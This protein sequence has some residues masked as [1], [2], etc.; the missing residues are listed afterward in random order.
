MPTDIETITA[1]RIVPVVVLNDASNAEG[2]ASAL[3]AGGL[4]VA[5]V[6]FRT[7]AAQQSIKIM[8]GRG[9]LLVGAGTVITP[10]QVDEAVD[11][12]ASFIVSPGYSR[13]V[14]DEARALG[15]P[16]L[17][18]TVTGTEIMAALSDG[19]TTLKFFP[20]G[21]FGGP[22]TI[23]ALA[24]PFPQVSFIPTGGV[25]LDNVN[26]YLSLSCVPAVGGSWMVPARL[27]D[28]RKFDTVQ[29]LTAAAVRAVAGP[30]VRKD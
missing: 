27:V 5:E 10:R 29:E 15:V 8:A 18:G 26:D 12:G 17:P 3:V 23:K 24:A 30:D 7:K 11:A 13:E 21:A 9:D 4:P 22:K 2:L 28:G 1:H 6:T 25:S 16:V 20:A 19:L 14:L